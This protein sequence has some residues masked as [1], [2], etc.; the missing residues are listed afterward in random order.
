MRLS[1]RV[2]ILTCCACTDR[3]GVSHIL[4]LDR[5]LALCVLSSTVPGS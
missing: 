1:A 3:L 5:G 4:V 2:A